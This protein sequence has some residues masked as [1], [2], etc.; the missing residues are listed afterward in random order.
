MDPL[1]SAFS[2][3][4]V[5]VQN[6]YKLQA[7][8]NVSWLGSALVPLGSTRPSMH[9]CVFRSRL[10]AI[11]SGPG[12]GSTCFSHSQELGC[13]YRTHTNCKHLFTFS[14]WS[15]LVPLGSTS[16]S[17][18]QC[19]F[20]LR[21]SAICSVSGLG[22]SCFNHSQE[23]GRMYRTHTNCKLSVMFSGL[24]P[25]WF[26]VVP[27]AQACISALCKWCFDGYHITDPTDQWCP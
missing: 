2:R 6:T 21:L 14:A 9:K 16:P 17:M 7:F 8:I 22:S 5:L 25:P 23:I 15:R 1:G 24:V 10:S 12:L 20:R 13:V 26:H 27:P 11:C 4:R 19:V 3:S 18:H